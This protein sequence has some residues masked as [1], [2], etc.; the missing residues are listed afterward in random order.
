MHR[1]EVPGRVDQKPAVRKARRVGERQ[2]HRDRRR[3]RQVCQRLQA[4]HVKSRST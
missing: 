2:R 4:L 1:D 3:V